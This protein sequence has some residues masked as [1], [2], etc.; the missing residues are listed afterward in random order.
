MK[1]FFIKYDQMYIHIFDLIG[2]IYILKSSIIFKQS[3]LVIPLEE[4]CRDFWLI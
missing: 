2:F 4:L 1:V 3:V